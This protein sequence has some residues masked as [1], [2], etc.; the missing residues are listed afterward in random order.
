M[1]GTWRDLAVGLAGAIALVSAP[2]RAQSGASPAREVVVAP[3]VP[4][5]PT[6]PALGIR[7]ASGARV[8]PVASAEVRGRV[9]DAGAELPLPAASLR[10]EGSNGTSLSARSSLDG[11]FNFPEVP[12]GTYTLVVSR[13][14][15][16]PTRLGIVVP[17]GGALVLDVQ[18]T[19]LPV[20]LER[21][22]VEASPTDT[23]SGGV[24]S[25]DIASL[26][27]GQRAPRPVDLLAA[28]G[29]ALSVLAGEGPSRRPGEPGTDRDGRTLYI[30]GAKD[31]G[32]RVTLDG[33][34]L[35]APLHLGG[36]LPVVD[37][38]LM[39][40]PRL[41]TAGASPRHDGGTDYV[42]DL[43]TRAAAPD[44]LRAWATADLLTARVGGEMPL[45]TNG[46]ILVGAR[47][48]DEQSV[49]RA[50]GVES[51]YRYG[52]A[53]A[54]LQ[55]APAIGQLLRV[56][57][58]AT[59]EGIGIPRDQ[60]QDDASWENRAGAVTW[61]RTAGSTRSLVRAGYSKA[62][63]DLPLLTLTD[64]HL[65]ADADRAALLAERR[66]SAR[67]WETSLGVE[68]ERL[69]VERSVAGDSL[70][71][72]VP[73]PVTVS[74]CPVDVTCVP[75]GASARVA[76]QTAALYLDHRRALKP[77]LQLG[78]GIRSTVAPGIA[79]AGREIL[80]PRFALEALPFGGTTL[81]ASVGRFSRLATF[82]DAGAETDPSS[83]TAIYPADSRA[84][85][86]RATVTQV[87]LGGTQRWNHTLAGIVA[88]WSRP[89]ITP[90]GQ[91]ISQH[92][93]I[94]ASWRFQ[95]GASTL[96]ATYSRVVRAF[97]PATNDTSSAPDI[98]ARVEQLASVQG[99]A[100]LGRV[101]GNVSASYAHGLSFASVVLERPAASTLQGA[102]VDGP[103]TAAAGRSASPTQDAYLRVDATLSAKWCVG[104]PSCRL[105]LTPYARLL[106]ALDRRDAIFYYSDAPGHTTNRLAGIPALLS[107]GM[108]IDAARAAR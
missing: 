10:M 103:F 36:L 40:P 59:Q 79:G 80:L 95:H 8:M 81:R 102:P 42:L 74:T 34:A 92:H 32:A 48:V 41:W 57:G 43:S 69:Q 18:L 11:A 15:Y 17:A 7:P 55:L 29:G 93:G 16:R 22:Y 100:S 20:A 50:A 9:L 39:A 89:G 84:W 83:G 108:R 72:K 82:F 67:H 62:S 91:V 71:A 107:F 46:S 45:G 23:S 87:E 2:G 31:A 77:W 35:G 86:T 56:T 106:N 58:F 1:S 27:D 66:W 63:I 30:W 97:S 73:L 88:Y 19:R 61:E 90:V 75:L 51:G 99:S 104:G 38:D 44:S 24:A 96:L 3:V 98:A 70:G 6:I 12:P 78:A 4:S 54:R 47:R 13:M 68:W 65:R 60:G 53:L 26:A 76:G 49:A 52:D 21:V 85:L 37:E 64:G 25:V 94:D 33:I 101:T 28:Q 105:L 5:P 14:A